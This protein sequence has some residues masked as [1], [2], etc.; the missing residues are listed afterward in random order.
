MHNTVTRSAA[1]LQLCIFALLHCCITL[2]NCYI[3][4]TAPANMSCSS[5]APKA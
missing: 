4:C 1:V 2:L 5:G 3:R